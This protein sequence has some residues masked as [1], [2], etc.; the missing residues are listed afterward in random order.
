MKVKAATDNLV[1]VDLERLKD[2]C[3]VQ[4]DQ[5]TA[6]PSIVRVYKDHIEIDAE[7][8]SSTIACQRRKKTM[9]FWLHDLLLMNETLYRIQHPK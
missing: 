9:K 8:E 7:I 5:G 4:L 6:N 3:S 2:E 1:V